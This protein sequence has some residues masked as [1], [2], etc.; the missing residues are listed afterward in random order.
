MSQIK[1]I[2]YLQNIKEI[3]ISF[4]TIKLLKLYDDS[5]IIDPIEYQ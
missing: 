5:P 1:Y 2:K 4:F 3:I